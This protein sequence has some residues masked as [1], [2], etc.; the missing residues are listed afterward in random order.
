[1]LRA[2][3]EIGEQTLDLEG[4]ANHSGSVFG[5]LG[6]GDQPLHEEFQVR[7]ARAWEKFDP[8]RAIWTEDEGEYI[9]SVG[10]PEV[11]QW[12]I[13]NA[14][15]ILLS[16]SQEVRTEKLMWE[17][18]SLDQMAIKAAVLRISKRFGRERTNRVMSALSAGDMRRALEEILHYYDAAYTHRSSMKNNRVLLKLE[19]DRR[20]PLEIAQF[21]V[22]QV[23]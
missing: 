22:E 18:R 4:M 15:V 12:R 1:M 7:V 11:L 10:L 13:K 20:T 6:R 9:G 3:A 8:A 14:D 5:G 21:L 17:Y 19:A 23:C 16:A 2:L